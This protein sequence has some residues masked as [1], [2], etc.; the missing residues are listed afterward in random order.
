[1]KFVDR[2]EVSGRQPFQVLADAAQGSGDL[3]GEIR[4]AVVLARSKGASGLGRVKT[5]LSEVRGLYLAGSCCP[6]T[7]VALGLSAKPIRQ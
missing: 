6:A 7:T 2:C 5:S 3:A 4:D 1:M